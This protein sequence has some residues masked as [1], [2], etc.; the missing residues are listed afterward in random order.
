MDDIQSAS[1]TMAINEAWAMLAGVTALALVLL[2]VMG[3]IRAG[4]LAS[5]P[6]PASE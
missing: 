1:L 4:S 2:F 3:P 6:Q 5:N